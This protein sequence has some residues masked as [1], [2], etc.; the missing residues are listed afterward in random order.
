VQIW[1]ATTSA[2]GG[3]LIGFGNGAAGATSVNY[4]RHVYL[5][6]AGQLVFGV[7]NAGYYTT[8]GT[9]AYNDGRWHLATATFSPATG[10]KLYADGALVAQST[11]TKAAEVYNGYWRI[12]QDNLSG[13][14][15]APTSSYLAGAVAYPSVYDRVLSATEVAGQYTAGR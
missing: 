5:T 7:F 14:A 4:D 15:N 9:T 12:G 1:F 13:W 11:A 8:G 3:K 10:M 2:G 6:N